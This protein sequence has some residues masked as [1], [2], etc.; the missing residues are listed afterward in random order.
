MVQT[1]RL[2]CIQAIIRAASATAAILPLATYAAWSTLQ[3]NAAHTGYVPGIVEAHK[4]KLAWQAATDPYPVSGLAVGGGAVYAGNGQLHAIDA[5]TGTTRWT[6]YYLETG[7]YMSPPAYANGIVYVQTNGDRDADKLLRGL[8]SLTGASVFSTPYPNQH[9]EFQAPT[10][11]ESDVLTG[12]GFYSGMLSYNAFSGSAR[13]GSYVAQ[14]DGWTPAADSIF[15]YV[16]TR[17]PSLSD[18]AAELRIID[19]A[20]GELRHLVTDDSFQWSGDPVSP[21]VVLGNNANAF[22]INEA[23]IAIANPELSGKGRLIYWNLEETPTSSP[24]IERV[25]VDQYH[26]Q[27]ALGNGVLYVGNGTRVDALD[28]VSGQ[29]QWSWTPSN[30]Q[31]PS[32]LVLSDNTLFVTTDAATY[33]LDLASHEPVWSFPKGGVM[34]LDGGTLYLGDREGQLYAFRIPE[35][36]SVALLMIAIAALVTAV[37]RQLQRGQVHIAIRTCPL[38]LT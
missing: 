14:T 18:G 34:A 20:N 1:A 19:R 4:F 27:P 23:G 3:G 11:I 38:F 5:A 22:S 7:A 9:Y 29:F 16:Y 37:R 2:N 24:H 17:S 21:A 13:W 32:Q 10:P 33:A 31:K 28:E 25:L 15:A 36:R 6:R 26:G 8:S 35:P 30:G 12:G